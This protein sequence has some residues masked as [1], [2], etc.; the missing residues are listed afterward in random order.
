MAVINNVSAKSAPTGIKVISVLYYIGCGLLA[1]FAILMFVGSAFLGGLLAT[2]GS[3]MLTALG[4]TI[5]I[6]LG[7]VFLLFAVLYFFLGR[8]LWKLQNWARIVGGILSALAV[9][10]GIMSLIQGTWSVIVSL[11]ING[12]I[13]WYLFF[14][15][16]VK[17]AFA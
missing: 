16:E 9:L 3:E 13:V 14:N 8:G 10:S 12:F 4:A 7:V 1:I 17:N 2:L 15:Q 5:F 6:V 11:A